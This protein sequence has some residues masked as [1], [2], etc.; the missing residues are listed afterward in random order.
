MP[1]KTKKNN[2]YKTS[3][4]YNEMIEKNKKIKNSEKI[5]IINKENYIIAEIN[6]KKHNINENIRI[7]NSF[8]ESKKQIN[9]RDDQN[10]YKNEKEIKEKCIIKINNKII[11]FKYFTKFEKEGK[12]E[13]KYIFKENII[14]AD[15]MFCGCNSLT[16]LNLSSF[17]TQNAIN[18][19]EMFFRCYSLTNFNLSSFNTHNVTNMYSMFEGFNSLTNLN[20]SSLILKMLLIWVGCLKDVNL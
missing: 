16:N 11:S 2:E 7:I 17:N 13:I 4:A 18:L 8:E 14:K 5:N 1:R 15:F 20:L 3:R 9:W 10:S 6:I 19:R 12:Y